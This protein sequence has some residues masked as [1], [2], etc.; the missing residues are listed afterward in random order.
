MNVGSRSLVEVGVSMVLQDH[1]TREAGRVS[2]SF[3]TMM[4]DMNASVSGFE[5][6]FGNISDIGLQLVQGMYDAYKYSAE[7]HNQIFLTSKI[8]GANYKQSKDLMDKALEVN[9][10]TPLSAMDV[11]SGERFLAMAGN[12][13]E[14]IQDM[15]EPAAQLASIFSSPLGGKGGVAD[16]MT[17]IM[18]GFGIHS[19]RA[20][21]AAD[22]IFT[23]VTSA[24]MSL[25]DLMATV[26]Y[27]VADMRAAGVG[28]Q[29][30]AAA[31][32][33]LGD[34]GIQGTMAG[35]SLGNMVRYLNL[36]LAGQKKYGIDTLTDLGLSVDDFYDKATG[37]FKGLHNAML[38]FYEVYHNLTPLERTQDFYNMLGV[39]GMR[40]MIPILEAMEQSGDKMGMILEKMQNNSGVVDQTMKEY[41]KTNRGVIEAFESSMENLKVVFGQAIS[42]PYKWFVKA[43]TWG[44]DALQAIMQNPLGASITSGLASGATTAALITTVRGL[45][46]FV[47][48]IRNYNAV[49]T[50]ETT[51]LSKN[52]ITEL[53][54]LKAGFSTLSM[55]LKIIQG[56]QKAMQMA[57][58]GYRYN[59]AGQLINARTGRYVSPKSLNGIMIGDSIFDMLMM[60]M[61]GAG[62]KT[63]A[64]AAAGAGATMARTG[65]LATV[66]R[67]LLTFLGGPWGIAITAVATFL[68][69][70]FDALS[71]I[72]SNTAESKEAQKERRRKEA[73]DIWYEAIRMGVIDGMRSSKINLDINDTTMGSY[74]P[75]S[76]GSFD[77]TGS[78]ALIGQ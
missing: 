26:R 53:A 20:S 1:F 41:N 9:R 58:L 56:N 15:I 31:A 44:I 42:G 45:Y 5:D 2:Q 47:R 63:A 70:I 6:S 40:G 21:E 18:A 4:S 55:D 38:K 46:I 64:G 12:S 27:S 28:L 23:A 50:R 76:M 62:R 8:A 65:L 61:M 35:T 77:Y 24:N 17:N 32:G 78:G 25:D 60:A 49:M 51:L 22:D 67:G 37:K 39:R 54:V 66:G 43:G 3:R 68:P 71:G 52:A 48:G 14:A 11:A 30:L 36:T 59:R 10:Q 29:E 33:A 69:M 16:M 34:V 73:E 13:A 72:E 75:G 74:T 7:V 57:I 19:S